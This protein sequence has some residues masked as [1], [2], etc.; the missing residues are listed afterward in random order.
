[1][2]TNQVTEDKSKSQVKEDDDEEEEKVTSSSDCKGG[3]PVKAF[4]EDMDMEGLSGGW[5]EK[6]LT[7]GSGFMQSMTCI[8]VWLCTG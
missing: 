2:E 5:I 6:K 4:Q 7:K 8:F 3:D 1:M